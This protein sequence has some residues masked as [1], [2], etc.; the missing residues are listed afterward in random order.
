MGY[1]LYLTYNTSLFKFLV[2]RASKLC[3][4]LWSIS[5]VIMLKIITVICNDRLTFQHQRPQ[6]HLLRLEASYRWLG[7]TPC[8]SIKSPPTFR[9]NL[10]PPSSGSK[11]KRSIQLA[12]SIRQTVTLQPWRRRQYV[13]PKSR[14]ASTGLHGVASQKTSTLHVCVRF[15]MFTV[16]EWREYRFIFTHLPDYTVS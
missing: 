7:L 6:M 4:C 9:R 14:W 2:Y 12:R 3:T 11:D 10:L 16:I 13:P 15:E 5:A 8:S 1:I